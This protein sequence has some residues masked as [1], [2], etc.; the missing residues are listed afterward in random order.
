MARPIIVLAALAFV[1]S[2]A[3]GPDPVAPTPM[4]PGPSRRA[5]PCSSR[6]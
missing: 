4:R 1:A 6:S 3:A 5:T 2:Q